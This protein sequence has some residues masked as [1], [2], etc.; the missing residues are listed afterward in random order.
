MEM[1][2]WFATAAVAASV[3]LSACGSAPTVR[4]QQTFNVSAAKVQRVLFFYQQEHLKT[5]K[6]TQTGTIPITVSA[7][8]TGLSNFGASLVLQGPAAFS[9][10]G[11][12]V[13]HASVVTPGDWKPHSIR[14]LNE[15]GV[16]RLRGA[17]VITVRPVGGV[18]SATLQAAKISMTFEVRV[19][20]GQSAKLVWVGGIDTDTFKGRG[21]FG[22]HM[23]GRELD[24]AYAVEFIALI[25]DS[26]KGAGLL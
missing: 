11:V 22:S 19:I 4:Q 24:D 26:L 20:D 3:M 12:K 1:K 13:E 6:A 10:Y 5:T 15:F 7:D 17:T 21:L 16:E 2:R 9:R 14:V 25:A 18:A 8:E 23:S